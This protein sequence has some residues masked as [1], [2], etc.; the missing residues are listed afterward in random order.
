MCQLL[1]LLAIVLAGCK[2][3]DEGKGNQMS[4]MQATNPAPVSIG[5]KPKDTSTVQKVKEDVMAFD[6]IYDVAVVKGKKDILVAYKVKHLERFRMKDIEK[7]ITKRLEKDFP[8]ENFTVS[9]DYKI[10]L[11]AVQLKEDMKQPDFSDKQAEKRLKSIISLQ[12]EK[13]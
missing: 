2:E 4:L 10:F 12:K 6:E 11:E 1:L 9:S 5:D 3:A 7:N 8:K 13:T